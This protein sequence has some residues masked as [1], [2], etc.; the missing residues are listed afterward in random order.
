MASAKAVAPAK[1]L[2]GVRSEMRR[3][4]KKRS[5]VSRGVVLCKLHRVLDMIPSFQQSNPKH[6]PF[7]LAVVYPTKRMI[8]IQALSVDGTAKPQ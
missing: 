8:C 1:T 3:E 4:T 5:H 7:M 2:R 6:D